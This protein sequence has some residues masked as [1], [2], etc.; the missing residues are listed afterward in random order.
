M[1]EWT[2]VSLGQIST[3]RKGINYKSEDYTDEHSGHP[4]ITIKCFSKGGGYE[5][6]GIKYY[7]GVSTKADCLATGDILFSV[8][9]LTRAGDIVGSPLRVPY[10]SGRPALASMDCM[11]IDPKTSLCDKDFLYHLLMLPDVRRKMVTYSAGST[12]LHLDIRKAPSI[13]VRIPLSIRMQERIATI[14]NGIDISIEKTEALI[15]KYQQIKAGLMHDLF[16]RGVLPNGKLRPPRQQAPELYQE[17]TSGWIPKEWCIESVGKLLI[18]IQTGKSPSCS[19]V[20]ATTGDWGILKVSAIHPEGFRSNENKLVEGTHSIEP[21]YEVKDNDLLMT[22]ANTPEL[23]GL[24]CLVDQPQPRLMLCD[25]TLRL[26]VN[27]SIVSR[28][29]LFICLQQHYARK[30][31]ETSATGTS[32]SMKNISQDSI[33]AIQIAYPNAAEQSLIVSSLK[34]VAKRLDLEV[35]NVQKLKAYKLGLMQ[36]LLTGKVLVKVED[37]IL[38][39][40]H[41]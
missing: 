9:D 4:F 27:E 22:R 26:V 31:I 5:P 19:D 18:E 11:R 24:V 16:T 15:D 38:A 28:E 29:F 8:T 32:M 10:F 34:S 7:D 12:V 14:L 3:Q 20:A 25:K 23:V 39:S 35:K 37:P 6:T 2:S 40:A 17:T 33:R 1:S 41:G 36:D 21:L 13:T 30:Q